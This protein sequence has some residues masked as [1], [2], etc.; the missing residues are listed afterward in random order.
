MKNLLCFS[1]L[2]ENLNFKTYRTV[3]LL[4]VLNGCEAWSFKLKKER[5]LKVF[6]NRVLRRIFRP[7]MDEITGE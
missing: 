2:A 6:E 4:V 1:L 3:I 5:R 7:K